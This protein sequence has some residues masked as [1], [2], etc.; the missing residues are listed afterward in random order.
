MAT[1]RPPALDE[2]AREITR[3]AKQRVGSVIDGKWTLDSLLGLGGMAA[4]Y[5]STHRNGK[6]GAVK[7]L[8][9][10]E[11]LDPGVK[12]RFLREGYVANKV[13]HPGSVSV[14]DDDEAPDGTVYLVMELLEGESL[15]THCP[16]GQTI[17]PGDVLVMIDKLL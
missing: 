12:G 9:A 13:D 4:V 1:E 11:A 6:K 14:I 2:R 15:E 8:H 3:R 16:P 10:H 17:A 5:S 7:I